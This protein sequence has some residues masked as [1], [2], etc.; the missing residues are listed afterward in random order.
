MSTFFPKTAPPRASQFISQYSFHSPKQLHQRLIQNH[1]FNQ[2]VQVFLPA[3]LSE[4][5]LTTLASRLFQDAH[6]YHAH[7]PL[8]LF[9]TPTFM[10]H[11]RNGMIAISVQGTIDSKDVVCLDGK[12]NLIL[13][14]T[15]DTYEQLGLSGTPSKFHPDRQ[16]YTVKIDMRASSMTPGKPGFERIKWCFENTLVTVF[17]MVLGSVDDQGIS[18]PL[19]FPESARAT[20][21]SFNVQSTHLPNIIVPDTSAIRTIGKSELNWRTSV[22]ELYEWIGMAGMQSDRIV[23]GNKIDPFLCVYSAPPQKTETSVASSGWLIEVSG[24][25]PSTVI[26]KLMDDLRSTLNT[27]CS[28]PGWANFTV[29]GFQDSPISWINQEHGFLLTGE[30]YYSFFLWSN[31]FPCQDSENQDKGTYVMLESVGAHDTHS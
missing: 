23:M 27:T 20:R 8:T 19:S 12:G 13:S 14:L 31:N 6:Y 11:I 18:L 2:R 3:A 22:M 17:P 4:Q 1:P 7:V 25:V 24:L 21:L 10:Q 15:K 30:N 26:S 16:R 28:E 5:A 9:L 29:W